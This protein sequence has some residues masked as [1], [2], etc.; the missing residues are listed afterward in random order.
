M[1]Y[2]P[3]S[4]LGILSLAFTAAAV[5][6]MFGLRSPAANA[7]LTASP[8]L[9]L[10]A[11]G[12]DPDGFIAK[13]EFYQGVIKLGQVTNNLAAVTNFVYTWTNVPAGN[14]SLTTVAT[15][16]GG[17]ATTSAPVSLTIQAIAANATNLVPAES[18]W[19][20]LD[21]GTDQGTAWRA[22][23][24][25]DGGWA[26]G[27]AQLG[28]GDGDE[29]TE[30]GFGANAS[31]KYITT[32]FR[33]TFV[34]SNV[35]SLTNLILNVLR[36]DGV[37]VYLNGNE[38]FRDNL[39][40]GQNYLTTAPI[41]ISGAE[42]SV[43]FLTANVSPTFMVNGTNILA[44]EMHQNAGTSS[45]LSFDLQLIAFGGTA[46]NTPPLVSI[47]NPTNNQV[48][49][50]PANIAIT[51]DATDPDGSISKVEFYSGITK[52]GES[53]T[54]PWTFSWNGVAI[55][56]YNLRA[57]A[58]DN[59]SSTTTSAVVNVSVV[60]N[61]PPTVAITSPT[62]NQA[63][64]SGQTITISANAT[65][66]GSVSKVE[67]FADGLKLG[68]DLTSPYSFNWSNAGSGAHALVAIA[69]D[70]LSSRAT[71]SVVNITIA[72]NLTPT[73]SITSPAN[74]STFTAP[75]NLALSATASDPDGSVAK[76]EY[77]AGT[78]KVAESS[79]GPAYNT[80][81][82]NNLL[83]SYTLEAVAYD[84][85]G[86]MGTS[87][88][89]SVTFTGLPPATLIAVGS[90]WKYLDTGVDQGTAWVS[91]SFNDST[92]QSGPA[93]LGYG[94]GDEATVV[95]FGP[96]PNNKYITTYFRHEFVVAN[97]NA[98]S[99]LAFRLLRDDGGVVYLNGKE[100]F[101]SNM[102]GGPI[103]FGTT[104]PLAGDD[105]TIFFPTNTSASLLVNGTNVVA[106]EIH[107]NSGTSSDVS[108]DLELIGNT[109]AISNAPPTVAVVNPANNSSFTE[110]ADITITAAAS[111]PDSAIDKVEFFRNGNIKIG[112]S[113]SA[114][115]TIL[116]SGVTSGAYT[117]RA[118]ATDIFGA[119]GT[120]AVVNVSVSSPSAP[121]VATVDPVPG[122]V[123]NLTSITVHFSEA[124]SG[125]DAS[126][127]LINGNPAASVSG[128][129]DTYTFTFPQPLDGLIAINWAA[130]HGIQDLESTPQPFNGHGSSWQY[131][132]SDLVR[133][134]VASIDPMPGASL[135][136][137]K[138]IKITFSEIVGGVNASDLLI[139]GTPATGASGN[140]AGPYTFSF[141]QPTNG[142]VQLA[143]AAN[144]GIHDFAS[145][146]NLLVTTAWS[147]N[148][149]TNLVQDVVIN[150]IMYHPANETT[151]DEWVEIFNRGSNSVNLTG[152]QLT[153]GVNYS[154]AGTVLQ[155]GA[156][157]VVCA[158]L[159][160]FNTVYPG[161]TNV[162]GNWDGTLSNTGEE[163]RIEDAGASQVDS[164]TYADEGD[165]AL[166]RRN[167]PDPAG[168]TA[169][170]WD[171]FAD[172]DGLGKSAELINPALP[173]KSG[174]NWAPSTPVNGTPGRVNS[175]LQTNIAP[176]ILGLT[177]SPAIPK[178]TDSVIISAQL[179]DEQTNGLTA[180]LFFAVG[181]GSFASVPMFDDATHGDGVAGD[182]IFTATLA[183]N[184]NTAVVE[185]YVRATD[186]GNRVR[187]WPG[188]TDT[189]GTQA[190]NAL[191]QVDDAAN[192][193]SQP[194]YRLIMTP[195]EDALLT[196]LNS[197][198]PNN[199]SA[200][201][202]TLV[203]VNDQDVQIRYNIDIRHRGAG[204]RGANPP[205]YKVKIPSDRRW[206]G[207]TSI[208]LNTQFTHSQLAGSILSRK[209][210]MNTEQAIP[211]Q[212]RVNSRNLASSGL[213]QYGSYVHLEARDSD[214]AENHFPNDPNGNLY[215][216]TRPSV[217]LSYLGTNP[218]SYINAGYLKDS[219]SSE[220]DYTDI[221]NLT[222]ALSSATPD[223]QYTATVR[224]VADVEEWMRYF[225]VTVL[226]GYNETSLGTGA[227]D[228]YTMYRGINDPRFL[229]FFH[230]HDTDF[231]EGDSPC[232]VNAPVFRA[233][234][235]PV[236]N[237]FL[238]WPD[239]VPIFYAELKKQADTTFAPANFDP[240]L[241]QALNWVPS[242]VVANMKNFNA[243]RRA[244]VLSQIPLNLTVNTSTVL[245]SSNGF[246]RTTSGTLGLYGEA[247]VIETR[248]VLVNGLPAYWSAWEGRWTNNAVA[249]QPGI[250]NVLVQTFGSNNTEIASSTF[251]VWY[252][253]GTATAATPISGN[254]VWSPNAG[255][256]N[257]T[258]SL[259]IGNGATLTIQPGT[260][261]YVAPGATI[262]V[263]GTGRLLAE[264]TQDAHIRFTRQPAGGNWGSLDFISASLESRLAYVDFDSCGG[265]TIGGHSAEV[266]ANGSKVFF[267]HL[268][269][270]NTP[271]V[272][273]IS[274][275]A[276]SFIV[277]N[278]VFPTY[279]FATS[280][281]EMLHGVNGIPA[282]GYGI[283]RSNYF[284]HTYGFND[285]IDFTGGNRPSP[286]LQIIGNVF[287]GAG[288]DHLD[289]DSTDA[290]IEGNI[291][292]HAHRDTN[293]T[294]NPLDTA[295][296]ISGGVDFAGQY[297]E[298][299]IINNLFYDVDHAVLNKQ[300]GRFIFEGNT[301]VHVSKENG[302]GQTADI[303][304]FNFTDDALAL[305]AASIG[306]GAYVANNII[307]DCPVLVANY[308]A[309]NH[310][311]I[312]ESNLLP[313]PVGRA[314]QQ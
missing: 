120:S 181:G 92:W 62:N 4:V 105:G 233:A 43:T 22:L 216:A 156:Y 299:T 212:V 223:S 51:A 305:P 118:V 234:A 279:P 295:S 152:W 103:G 307:W 199:N 100:V 24:F 41:A 314:R 27:P 134:T 259:T 15:D 34:Y 58:T 218:Q 78:L 53:L 57:V 86:A 252:D 192:G 242:Q 135:K 137:L 209:A 61:S 228:D 136:A 187:T 149:N 225:A 154:F 25:P 19:K 203:T 26:S 166:R 282:G 96:D 32:Y 235:L 90:V 82:T 243:Q 54:S 93:Q 184:T 102:P 251:T 98:Y 71:S 258:A 206:N 125:V 127:L 132:L 147:Y 123:T 44:V 1:K 286:I 163:I 232:P 11:S 237:R 17:S 157:L 195:A 280:G 183:P 185:F 114:P 70:N 146:S 97:R 140:G 283:F 164:V 189:I 40:A 239:F 310:T 128:S 153:K 186:S 224:Q 16:N 240:V 72:G 249:L 28:Y 67:F 165:W 275:D 176:M 144:H 312:F 250:N 281:P 119:T 50:A 308:S 268:T 245:G 182:G 200:M 131:I 293:R 174:Q 313:T 36:D 10:V 111:D 47:S 236:V 298:W 110:P 167:L 73:V 290:W 56:S 273:Y 205:N 227:P 161:I 80:V 87:A 46:T 29:V 106:V 204:S 116:W 288:D 69:T 272:E 194:T 68:E 246:L 139:N 300:G 124:V 297:S 39:G 94:E 158:S 217:D 101:R 151:T 117:I 60:A 261:V 197:T 81:W 107:Q 230:D 304:A 265:T 260:T 238:K 287:D 112:E 210:G 177:H 267:D 213:R 226:L 142:I 269:F 138:E 311:V 75:T 121:T 64:S 5:A 20:Y 170:G 14:Y 66:N 13:V 277:Q 38:I 99:S 126:D 266:H 155:P 104:A 247:N 88:P 207:V 179:V 148:L 79:T 248:R 109:G 48:F 193:N 65:D 84:L 89:V 95:S 241:D 130:N 8:T 31:A 91:N 160:R 145:A 115:Y 271:T 309:T 296:A 30:I 113:L 222:Y 178:S 289:L 306:A 301:L 191:Y 77:Y 255:P 220:N 215:T 33:K 52:I 198:D 18:V 162:V 85:L 59:S 45:D 108:F 12:S 292:M 173:N 231:G 263:T 7:V 23:S 202:A 169:Y 63:F 285:T 143:W 262:S 270:A 2:L 257:V 201:N 168:S 244:F 150:E 221:I 171:W 211:V 302:S 122:N 6:P 274:F 214:Y 21:N 264:G 175:A 180:T 190:A 256:Y 284:G 133:P 303:A 129:A 159:A 74:N 196:Q 188:P 254:V 35:V 9:K 229:L 172:H 55:G 291:F 49:G 294:D 276:S 83:G 278:S 3:L 219:N 76:V 208:N 37:V 42:E 253:T 141:S